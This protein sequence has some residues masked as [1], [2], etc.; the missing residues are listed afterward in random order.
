MV[1]NS[2]LYCKA[3]LATIIRRHLNLGG[4]HKSDAWVFPTHR[5]L[6]K[7]L[8][9]GEGAGRVNTGEKRADSRSKTLFFLIEGDQEEILR[10]YQNVFTHFTN[11]I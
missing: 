1:N 8:G 10:Q 4:L 5:T 3:T 9:V 7:P 11:R 6:L 2:E